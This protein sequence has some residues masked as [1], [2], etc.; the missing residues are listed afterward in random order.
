MRLPVLWSRILSG[1]S[2]GCTRTNL[3]IAINSAVFP[4]YCILRPRPGEAGGRPEAEEAA[5]PGEDGGVP[6]LCVGDAEAADRFLTEELLMEERGVDGGFFWVD[7]ELG[8]R[9]G[10]LLVDVVGLSA[11][12]CAE[13]VRTLRRRPS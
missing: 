7:R 12:F 6:V 3:E 10:L 2:P 13:A 9:G 8:A 4:L 1:A 5:L 11:F